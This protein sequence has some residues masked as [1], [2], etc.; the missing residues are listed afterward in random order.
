MNQSQ[1]YLFRLVTKGECEMMNENEKI[2]CKT[3]S[4]PY[5]EG[6]LLTLDQVI[7]RLS[8]GEPVSWITLHE[9][10]ET[11]DVAIRG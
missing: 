7:T 6:M 11:Y 2:C 3:S 4:N 10:D 8:S 1:F 9:G 5:D